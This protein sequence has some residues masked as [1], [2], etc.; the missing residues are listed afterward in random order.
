[1]DELQHI[2]TEILLACTETPAGDFLP[3]SSAINPNLFTWIKLDHVSVY[4]SSSGRWFAKWIKCYHPRWSCSRDHNPSML[5]SLPPHHIVSTD[6]YISDYRI[7]TLDASN[8]CRTTDVETQYMRQRELSLL[9]AVIGAGRYVSVQFSSTLR[10]CLYHYSCS[11]TYNMIQTP[12]LKLYLIEH[13]AALCP[14]RWEKF[15]WDQGKQYLSLFICTSILE[16]HVASEPRTTPHI[17]VRLFKAN[18]FSKNVSSHI[19]KNFLLPWILTHSDPT[20]ILDY[21]SP[22]LSA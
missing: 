21:T 6:S 12:L 4:I 2:Y 16:A 15:S 3:T 19:F 20:S 13:C 14:R 18:S 9:T 17:L 10:L 8:L 7:C 5:S 22:W 11:T 1:M